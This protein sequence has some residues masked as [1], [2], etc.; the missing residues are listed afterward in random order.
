M[1]SQTTQYFVPAEFQTIR[2][3]SEISSIRFLEAAFRDL[4]SQRRNELSE[5]IENYF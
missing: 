4:I 5:L 1:L 3:I 2:F